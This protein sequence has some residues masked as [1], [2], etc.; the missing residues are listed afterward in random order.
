MEI[1]MPQTPI[2]NSGL[3]NHHDLISAI[4]L[5][6]TYTSGSFFL[7]K[8]S[9]SLRA[10]RHVSLS[11]HRGEVMGLVGESGS[12][13]STFGK[14]LLRLTPADSGRIF[15]DGKEI[16]HFT[17]HEMQS[18]RRRFQV[19]FQD[20]F[21]SLSP[22]MNIRNIIAEPLE[23][24]GIGNFEE[25]TERVAELLDT[26]GLG[27]S[28]LFRYPHEFSGGQRQRI[29]I[30][31]ALALN[32]D[33]LLA[34]EAVSALDVSLQAQIVNLLADMKRRFSLTML[35]ITHDLTLMRYLCDR[36]AVM[37][38]GK[39]V[40][41]GS[42]EEI[43]NNPLH[44]YT[45]ILLSAIPASNPRQKKERIYMKGERE[46]PFEISSAG[47]IFNKRCPRARAECADVT[48][49]LKFFSASNTPSEHQVACLLAG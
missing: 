34:D 24:H 44:P 7:K 16:T 35:F 14:T 19:I 21:A 32:P 33:F 8:T 45:Q 27:T 2:S 29:G 11:I 3:K 39:I 20:P 43:C 12:G 49:E 26:V 30:A 13:K 40:E 42:A 10:L 48:P 22:R 36:I 9:Q 18:I 31:R 41:T 5:S 38:L 4:N 23:I 37:Y 47:C 46:N 25:R 1:D 6:K 28:H 17:P 15:V